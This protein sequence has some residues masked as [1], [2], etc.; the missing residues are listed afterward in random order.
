MPHKLSVCIFR[1]C[2]I[3]VRAEMVKHMYIHTYIHTNK[4]IDM[5]THIIHIHACTYIHVIYYIYK[6]THMY[7]FLLFHK[8]N[9]LEV[10]KLL[11]DT[12]QVSSLLPVT[13]R[14]VFTKT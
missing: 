5:H 9:L 8:Y 3:P 7:I 14:E 6:Y 1:L 12:K 4:H 13:C 10:L 11:P 2:P